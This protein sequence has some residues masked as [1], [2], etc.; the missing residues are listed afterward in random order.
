MPFCAEYT[1]VLWAI[2]KEYNFIDNYVQQ[3]LCQAPL[4]G[5]PLSETS[6]D[7]PKLKIFLKSAIK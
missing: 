7:K 3:I 1:F 2:Y 6:I 4:C 5:I